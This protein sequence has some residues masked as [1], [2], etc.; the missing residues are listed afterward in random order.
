FTDRRDAEEHLRAVSAQLVNAQE[1]ERYHIAEE[2]HD[3]LAQRISA[4]SIGLTPLSQK[5][6]NADLPAD[7]HGLQQ[8]AGAISTDIVRCSYQRRPS[9]VEYLGLPAALRGLCRHAANQ[10]Q[11][12]VVFA[13]DESLPRFSKD[14]S[15]PLYRIAQEAVRNA[16]THSGATSIHV[17]LSASPTA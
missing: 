6:N 3:G 8:Q 5:Y 7:L 11:R 10:Q 9:S 12:V 17:E 15:L 13:Q 1:T 14:I 4:L 2:L 16:L